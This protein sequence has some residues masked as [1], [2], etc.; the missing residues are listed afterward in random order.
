[1]VEVLKR[2]GKNIKRFMDE[3]IKACE[4]ILSNAQ[5]RL[6]LGFVIVGLGVGLGGGLI[7]SA[8]ITVSGK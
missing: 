5:N 7:T 2:A 8:Y 3:K 4:E 6:I 1:M